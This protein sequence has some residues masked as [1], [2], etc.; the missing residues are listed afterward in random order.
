MVAEMF[1]LNRVLSRNNRAKKERLKL[2]RL[3]GSNNIVKDILT[4]MSFR[5]EMAA[6]ELT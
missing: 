1:L 5:G 4:M 3:R 6:G 2:K